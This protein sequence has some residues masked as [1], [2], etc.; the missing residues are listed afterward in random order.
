ML[1]YAG[2]GALIQV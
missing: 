2:Y 1:M